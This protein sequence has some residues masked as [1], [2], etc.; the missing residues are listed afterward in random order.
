MDAAIEAR[1]LAL[2]V[3]TL[4]EQISDERLREIWLHKVQDGSSY[5][6]FKRKVL[7]TAKN[8][9][10]TEREQEGIVAQSLDILSEFDPEKG[11]S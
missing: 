11:V 8:A 10:M 7:F 1:G 6:A 2:F 4:Q 3:R 5:G 9:N